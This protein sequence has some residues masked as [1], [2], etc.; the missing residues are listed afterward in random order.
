MD[1]TFSDEQQ[2]FRDALRRYLDK[3]YAFDA[4][5]KIVASEAGADEKHWRAF[6]ELG[7]LAL[8]VPEAHGGFDGGPVDMLVV[9]QE[10][11]RA[12]VVEP[13]WATA[14]G[15]EALRLGAHK[16]SAIAGELLERAARG[17]IRLSVAFH[18][19]HARYDLFDLRTIASGEGERFTLA[20]TKSMVQHGAQA[21]YWIVPV[22]VEGEVALFIVGKDAANVGITEYRTIDGQRAATLTF[23]ATPATR[24]AG[25]DTGAATFGRIADYA[26]F[27]LCAEALGALD[28][29]N[30]ATVD[31]TKARQQFGMP[32]A[33]FQVL[34]HRMV[35]MLIHTEQARSITYL[36]AARY[37]SDDAVTR[38]QAVSAAKARVGQAARF[39]GQQAVQLHGGM[40]MTNELPAA[41]WFK[42]LSI[43]ETTLGDVDHH[44]ARFAALPTF[45]VTED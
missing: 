32:I 3:E 26:T 13:Y 39:V 4:R 15:I 44:L 45:S 17:E 20:G 37:A 21:D 29:L 10:L 25:R 28:A 8:P 31:Y 7:L 11:G 12:L 9:M 24:L 18:E 19:P 27:L 14:A 35:D 16:G 36:A 23:D 38:A 22:R 6:A 5:Q 34:Q 2:Q 40:G 33:R 43:I 42:R 30:R 41:H 1:F